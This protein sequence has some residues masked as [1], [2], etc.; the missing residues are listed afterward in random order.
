MLGPRAGDYYLVRHGLE[1]G[2]LVV[3]Q[4]SFK[5][6]AE[7]QIQAKPSMM[8]PE[9]GGGGGRDH[10][11]HGGT[12]AQKQQ[13][14]EHAGHEMALPAELIQQLKALDDANEQAAEAIQ[15]DDLPKATAAF[16]RLSESLAAVDGSLFTGHSRMVWREFEML[17]GNDAI[18]GTDAKQ[19]GEADRVFLLLKGHMRRLR[20]QLGVAAP[21]SPEIERLAVA[22]Q[23]QTALE[24]VW[25]QYLGVGQALANDNLADATRGVD[26]LESELKAVSDA[27]L[28]A[29]AKDVW[30]KERDSLLK[31]IA[32]LQAAE[33]IQSLRTTFLPVSQQI[34]VLARTFGFGDQSPVFELHC[35]MAFQGNG[36]VWYQQDDQVQNPYFGATMLKC[37]DRV[38]R[39]APEPVAGAEEHGSHEG[40]SQH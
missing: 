17:L 33:D 40:H 15:S 3:T 18:E 4:G 5:I 16:E 38:D 37:A 19:M 29:R 30:S 22:P 36:A 6:D 28:E 11:G 26:D 20:E 8:T 9:G 35:P 31:L 1:A 2:E 21:E 34:G 12:A 14:D 23:F 32:Q 10:G 27:P 7:I 39:I 25:Q 13:T 24:L